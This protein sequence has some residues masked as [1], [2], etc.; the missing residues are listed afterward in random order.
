[1]GG[2]GNWVNPG[3]A[4]QGQYDVNENSGIQ[5]NKH[6]KRWEPIATPR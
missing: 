2:T 5:T 4:Q 1:M 6:G 3:Q